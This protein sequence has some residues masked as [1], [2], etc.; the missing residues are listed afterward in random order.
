MTLIVFFAPYLWIPAST[1]LL[2][3]PADIEVLEGMFPG[4]EK[5]IRLEASAAGVS[6][7]KTRLHGRGC[8]IPVVQRGGFDR[9]TRSD[10]S[11]GPYE[12][13]HTLSLHSRS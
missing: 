4:A 7:N 2:G 1:R 6:K 13:V 11:A 9:A 5:D 3:R 8:T 12:N 10:L